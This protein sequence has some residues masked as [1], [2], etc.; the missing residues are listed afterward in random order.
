MRPAD[1]T[2]T[3]MAEL[4]DAAYRDDRG[5]EGEGLEPE[6]RQAL[7]AYLGSHEDA[8][9]AAWEVWQEL[10]PDEPE[11]AVSADIEYWLDVEFIEP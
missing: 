7:A 8:R 5:L 3:E 6:D 10:F 11:Y 4:L 1:L 2:P 9:A